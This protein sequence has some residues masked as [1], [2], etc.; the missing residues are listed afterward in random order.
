MEYGLSG[1]VVKDVMP[2]SLSELEFGKLMKTLGPRLVALSRGICRDGDVAEDIVQ[3]AFVKLWRTPPDGP[4]AVIPSW[5][6]RVVTNLS[7]NDLRRRKR[8]SALPEFSTDQALRDDAR[9]EDKLDLADNVRR[10]DDALGALPEEKRAI[11]VMR[12]YE[13]M[14]YG[15]ISKVLGVPVGT[16][17]SRLNRAREA[18]KD[19]VAEGLIEPECEPLVFKLDRQ[20]KR[21]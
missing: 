13:Q 5:M 12:V 3:E 19:I 7:I 17:M 14:S 4:E 8:P 1:G 2:V 15:E 11:I 10:V 20:R 9:P 18:L 21:G 6:R 16:V